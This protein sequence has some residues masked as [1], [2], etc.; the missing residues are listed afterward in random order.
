MI[1]ASA[2]HS[3]DVTGS[4]AL[5][6]FPAVSV[7]VCSEASHIRKVQLA[8]MLLHPTP[9]HSV[10]VVPGHH[11][12]TYIGERLR[13]QHQ[14]VDEWHASNASTLNLDAIDTM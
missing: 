3:A 10:L 14:H 5:N 8:Q 11:A 6:E 2:V 4:L 9:L 13:S 1:H 7:C 12:E